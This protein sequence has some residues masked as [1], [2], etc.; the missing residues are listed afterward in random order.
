MSS[1]IDAC[2]E[3]E[4]QHRVS[5]EGWSIEIHKIEQADEMLTKVLNHCWGAENRMSRK[6]LM[7]CSD[8]ILEIPEYYAF[9]TAPRSVAMQLETH[10]K[11]HRFYMW[12]GTARKDRADAIKG[13][14][15]REQLVPFAMVFTARA[16]KEISHYRM[17][18]KAEKPTRIFMN[19]LQLKLSAV[20]MELAKEMMPM[21][22]YRNGLC[23]ELNSCKKR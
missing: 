14:Y 4:E 20:D 7:G 17:C 3:W 11:K 12:M 23:T 2:A 5:T 19:F 16:I 21:C 13:E 22:T 6:R 10:K 15:S 9:C 18:Q 8:S 1:L